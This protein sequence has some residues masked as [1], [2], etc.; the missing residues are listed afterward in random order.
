M[1]AQTT[2]TTTFITRTS[3][4]TPMSTPTCTRFTLQVVPGTGGAY[5]GQYF[6]ILAAEVKAAGSAPA[7][8]TTDAGSASTFFIDSN[9]Y[10]GSGTI[11]ANIDVG[12]TYEQIYFNPLGQPYTYATCSL[13]AGILNCVDGATSVL[14]M[15]PEYGLTIGATLQSGNSAVTLQALGVE[16]C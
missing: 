16:S 1:A 9:G 7:T 12:Q 3:T 8:L 6:Q 15:S 11:Y 2:T 13:Q 14:Q 5:S 4:V 10:L